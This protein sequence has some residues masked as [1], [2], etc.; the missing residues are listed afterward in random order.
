[1]KIW[2]VAIPA[3]KLF[4]LSANPPQVRSD[5]SDFFEKKQ[6]ESAN[7]PEYV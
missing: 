3:V 7:L 2:K 6:C 5:L 4:L 1:M